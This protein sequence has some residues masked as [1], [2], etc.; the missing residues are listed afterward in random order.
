MTVQDAPRGAVANARRSRERPAN[1]TAASEPARPGD[2]R[3]ANRRSLP[4]RPA[5]DGL[6]GLGVLAIMWGHLGHADGAIYAIDAFFLLSG[7]LITGVLLSQWERRGQIYL[8]R[9]WGRRARRLFPALFMVLLFA[10]FYA[11]FAAD[12]GELIRIRGDSLSALFYVNNWYSIFAGNSYF[13]IFRVPS[14]LSHIWTLSV[15]EQYYLAWPLMITGVLWLTRGRERHAR[16]TALFWTAIGLALAS[17]VLMQVMLSNGVDFNHLYLGTDTRAFALLSGSALAIGER[18]WGCI[19]N[20]RLVHVL[21]LIGVGMLSTTVLVW[22]FA[23]VNTSAPFRYGFLVADAIVLY[24]IWLIA[25]PRAKVAP[26]ILSFK[27]LVWLGLVSYG[28]YLWHWPIFVWLTPA[29]MHMAKGLP[30]DLIVMA[31][32]IAVA[33]LSFY[34]VEVPVLRGAI[35]GRQARIFTPAAA[36]LVAIALVFSTGGGTTIEDQ[37]VGLGVAPTKLQIAV[38]VP[39]SADPDRP[40]ILIVG[41]SQAATLGQGF[42]RIQKPDDI[43]AM[44]RGSVGCGIAGGKRSGP[45]GEPISQFG[46]GYTFPDPPG[47]HDW[48]ARWRGYV[49]S[50]DPTVALLV[51][52]NPRP[53]PRWSSATTRKCRARVA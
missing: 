39:R 23:S 25:N 9:F 19:K 38:G 34:L 42:L 15:E 43:S 46:G 2:A 1:A 4:Y 53:W 36:G 20:D 26:A 31:I 28:L 32:S 41:D 29:R 27:P 44:N 51:L 45:D 30:Y 6:R 22:L 12:P 16:L 52:G 24:G 8:K 33:G 11:R 40:H 50:Y 14:P 37:A 47:C 10:A 17:A 35:A 13:D 18:L 48:P 7:Y 21:D 49:D 5:Y 3:P